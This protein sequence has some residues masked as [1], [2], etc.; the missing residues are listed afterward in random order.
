M[1]HIV[2]ISLFIAISLHSEDFISRF[3]YGQMLYENPRGVSCVPCHGD[4]GEGKII[5][6]YIT[7]D[8][9]QKILKGADIRFATLEDMLKAVH[10]GP[11]VMPKYF[12][13]NDEIEAIYEY[14]QKVNQPADENST[15]MDW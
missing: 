7:D 1:R 2:F 9:K 4:R 11:G 12:L 8:G 14:I 3:E 13:T 5:A 6:S 15:D 10:N